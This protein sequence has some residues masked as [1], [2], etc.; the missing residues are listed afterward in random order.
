[1]VLK[2]SL[3]ILLKEKSISNIT[4]KELCEDAD[5]NRST[6]YSHYKDV[7]DLL[8]QIEDDL[9]EDMNNTLK[10][11]NHNKDEEA[12][13]MTEKLLEYV[14]LNRD[15]CQTLLGE[16]GDVSFQK[17][18]MEIARTYMMLEIEDI[19]SGSSKYVSVFTL[20]GCIHVIKEWLKNG[21]DQPPKE[22][23][24]I[25]INVTKRGLSSFE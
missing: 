21:V 19:D 14:S 12:L 8:Y 10:S 7:Y 6:F 3:I 5:I 22:M 9:L 2:E 20:S 23:A 18:V 25:I 4:I 16:H 13:E 11:Y 17:R 24:K 15:I 1:M